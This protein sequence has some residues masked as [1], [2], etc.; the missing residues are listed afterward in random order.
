M[1]GP[2]RTGTTSSAARLMLA[3]AALL[4]AGGAAGYALRG[5]LTDRTNTADLVEQREGEYRFI[6]PLLECDS[7]GNTLRNRELQPFQE[8]VERYIRTRV[9]R[10]RVPDVAVYFRELND[11]LWFSIG[12]ED[13]FTPASLRKVPLMIALLKQAERDTGLLA[14]KIEF[15]LSRDYNAS[16]N[17]KP[18]RPMEPGRSY[19]V[20]DLIHRMIVFSDNNAF[21]LLAT[22]VDPGILQR[23]YETLRGKN[24][25]AAE[26]PLGRS[27]PS[28]LS[29]SSS[30]PSSST[31]G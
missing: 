29:P 22:V 16:Q 23:V 26:I 9:D 1:R 15:R 2:V 8:A 28:G 19:P 6:N 18:S 5:M 17:I 24:L 25:N 4:L 21:T 31:W 7:A 11:G 27:W 10:G 13:R 30:G 14:R 3:A 12:I 20:G